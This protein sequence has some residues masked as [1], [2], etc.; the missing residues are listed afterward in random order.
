MLEVE[1]G[2]K[3]CVVIDGSGT[4]RTHYDPY[5][6][7]VTEWRP[8]DGTPTV[9]APATEYV[10]PRFG[11]ALTGVAA[12]HIVIPRAPVTEEDHVWVRGRP[13]RGPRGG[14]PAG[15]GLPGVPRA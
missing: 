5:V 6:R 11:Q 1:H 15:G 4:L 13:L 2:E 14:W 10:V 3:P 7:Y 9:P 12:D 8:A